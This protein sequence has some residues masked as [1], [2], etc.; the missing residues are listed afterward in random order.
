MH[1]KNLLLILVIYLVGAN[2]KTRKQIQLVIDVMITTAAVMATLG[3]L[4]TDIVGGHRVRALQSTTMTWGALSAVFT[5]I[6]ASLFLFGEKNR[7]RWL[8]LSAF[9]FQ[10]VSMLFSYVRGAWIG[11]AAG[12]LVLAVVKSKKLFFAGLVLILIAFLLAPPL[13]KERI[14]SITDLSV[15]STQVRFVQ[16]RNAVKIF[17]DYPIIGV[18]WIDLG[19]LHR[20][21]APP[22]A[23][24]S[25]HAYRIGHF[26]NNYIMFLICFGVI[27]FAAA[28]F[29]IFRLFQAIVRIY[30][31]IPPEDRQLSAFT[32]GALASATAFW[33]NGFFDWTFGDAEPVTLLWLTVGLCVAI[34]ARVS[35]SKTNEQSVLVDAE[36]DSQ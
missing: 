34:G 22:G 16:W 31:R 26:H 8:Y 23:D 35:Q 19:A 30:R 3:L 6:T 13:V 29:M 11:F 5:L 25:Y 28:C 15:N 12:I 20:Q 33:V 4:T 21:Y 17:E 9:I 32:V 7:K 36:Q 10:F 14:L 27:G 2:L 24:L 1:L 18:G